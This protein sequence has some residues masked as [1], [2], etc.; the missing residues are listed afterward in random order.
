[1]LKDLKCFS[2]SQIFGRKLLYILFK[3]YRFIDFIFHQINLKL[4]Y[5]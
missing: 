5:V 3:I 2:K 4:K 1:M